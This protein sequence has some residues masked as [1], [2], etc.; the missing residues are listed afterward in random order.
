METIS[1]DYRSLNEQLH[2]SNPEYGANGHRNALLVRQVADLYNAESI[3]DYGCG[4]GTLGAILRKQGYKVKEFDP[5]IKGKDN[6]PEPCDVVYCGDVA[7]HIEPEF[8]D[9]FLDDLHRV[10]DRALV[11]T[12]A[13]RAAKKV[14]ADGRNAHLIQ[15][16]ICWWLPKLKERFVMNKVIADN[17]EFQFFGEPL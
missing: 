14:L 2:A 17:G 16:D 9:A 6:P 11:L 7:E 10:T 5:A 3:L 4:K 15:E 8:V 1:E 12:V 13:T